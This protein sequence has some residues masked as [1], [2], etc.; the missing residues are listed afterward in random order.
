MLW[1]RLVSA[2]ERLVHYIARGV[3][4][5]QTKVNEIVN[6]RTLGPGV[7]LGSTLEVPI[8]INFSWMKPVRVHSGR[9]EHDIVSCAVAA[10]DF[11]I[12]GTLN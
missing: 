11:Q 3:L 4:A 8:S 9:V 10:K 2:T 5:G 6:W 1:C 7:G 12:R